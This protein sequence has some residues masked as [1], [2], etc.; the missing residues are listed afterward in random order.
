M[1]RWRNTTQRLT[2]ALISNPGDKLNTL[3]SPA[4]E[5]RCLIGEMRQ[6]KDGIPY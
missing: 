6:P 2:H 3:V 5:S 1:G 4:H